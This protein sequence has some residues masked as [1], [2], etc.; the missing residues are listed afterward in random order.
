MTHCATCLGWGKL[1]P[2]P[3]KFFGRDGFTTDC[4]ECSGTGYVFVTPCPACGGDGLTDV[5]QEA[6]VS[7]LED[8]ESGKTIV[9][10]GAGH[11]GPRG[12]ARGRL[13]VKIVLRP[14]D[15]HSGN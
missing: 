11:T 1:R 9:I 15:S 7:V 8:V 12:G 5:E 3:G 2:P 14:S 13:R 10:R 4:L 6:A